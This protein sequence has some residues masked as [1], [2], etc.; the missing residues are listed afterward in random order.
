M[1]KCGMKMEVHVT[2][3]VDTDTINPMKRRTKNEPRS[4]ADWYDDS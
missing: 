3:E 2:S 4:C 1:S